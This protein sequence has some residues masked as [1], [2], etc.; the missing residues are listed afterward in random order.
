MPGATGN[1]SI[2]TR[3][4]RL[5]WLAGGR[6]MILMVDSSPGGSFPYSGIPASDA[7]QQVNA[8]LNITARIRL[9]DRAVEIQLFASHDILRRRG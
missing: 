4:K 8:E 9:A 6:A 1:I 5:L 2:N 7:N 3:K